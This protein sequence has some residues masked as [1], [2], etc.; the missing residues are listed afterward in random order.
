M[1]DKRTRLAE[2]FQDTQQFYNS[3]PT[4][5]E[6]VNVSKVGTK[7]YED[8]RKFDFPVNNNIKAGV[9]SITKSKT[10]EA[11]I[12][13]NKQHPDKRIAVLNFAS[14]SRPGGGVKNGSSA[15][16]ESLCRCST[17]YPTLDRRVLWQQYYDVN[18]ASG[19]VL[20]TDAC[21]YSP[22][23]II[24]KTDTDFPERMDEKEWCKVDVI[25]CAAPNLRNEPANQYNPE[26]GKAVSI[27]PSVLQKIHEQRARQILAVAA[28]NMIDILV[29]GAFGCGAFRNDPKV[30]A[31]A[32]QNVLTDH[33]Q[34][35][36]LI[37]FAIY[38]RD[39]ETENYDTFQKI[40]GITTL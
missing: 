14:A 30:V 35:F 6:S 4:L 16:E 17:L 7:L 12:R 1:M 22:G 32:Y 2:I 18:R 39:Y 26:T 10:Y 9:V 27:L 40:F 33:R 23:V 31:K 38:C 37:E 29:L 11:A 25:S 28:D 21:I 36:D 5:I 13:L 3:N 20:H 15:Q 34:Y 24:F 8:G 19:N